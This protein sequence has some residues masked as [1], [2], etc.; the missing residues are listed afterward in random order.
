M[1]DEWIGYGYPPVL[2]SS[3]APDPVTKTLRIV[4]ALTLA[5]ALLGMGPVPRSGSCGG[6]CCAPPAAVGETMGSQA[7]VGC[8]C[9]AEAPNKRCDLRQGEG[10]DAPAG[11]LTSVRRVQAPTAYVLD[12]VA[13]GPLLSAGLVQVPSRIPD[14]LA[15]APPGPLYLQH[16]SLLC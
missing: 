4:L 12:C 8:G 10:R 16:L 14:P 1:I 7:A 6:S 3:G 5:L 2:K 13:E 9:C 11:A 15:T